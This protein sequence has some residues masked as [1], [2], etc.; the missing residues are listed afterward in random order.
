[1]GSA[2]DQRLTKAERKEQARIEREEIQRKQSARK[3]NRTMTLIGVVV[4]AAVAIG[5]VVLLGGDGGNTTASPTPSGATVPDPATLPGILQTPPPWDNNLAQANERL[6]ALGLP[7]L[8]DTILHHHL[9]LWI[10][11]DGQPVVV[12]MEV[13]FSQALQVFSPLHT[14]DA[15]GLV[16][17]ESSDPNFQPVL[18][19]FMDVWGVYFTQTCLGDA[20]NDGDRQLRVFLDGQEYTGDPTL[21]PLTDQAAV[22]ITM[23][24][25]DQLPDPMTVSF[26]FCA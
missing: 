24:T 2:D 1:M 3:R 8:S 26:T 14:H 7:E 11:V 4:L 19:Q 15:T 5:L 9:H 13:G 20:C 16:H 10:Y 17:V 21:L 18:A 12:P 22:F 6:S 25:K 23:G